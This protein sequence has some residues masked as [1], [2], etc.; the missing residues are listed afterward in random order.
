[1]AYAIVRCRQRGRPRGCFV[2][3]AG[4]TGKLS[5]RSK[6]HFGHLSRQE[7]GMSLTIDELSPKFMLSMEVSHATSARSDHTGVGPVGATVFAARLAPC[8]IPWKR[9]SAVTLE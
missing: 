5:T 4:G 6:L 3:L 8:P 9:R 2:S 1:M 7:D